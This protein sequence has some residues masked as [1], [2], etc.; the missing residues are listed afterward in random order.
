MTNSSG[1]VIA[2]VGGIFFKIFEVINRGLPLASKVSTF[3]RFFI[4]CAPL[5]G[6]MHDVEE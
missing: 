5:R 3:F 6:W 4:C 1:E 2:C